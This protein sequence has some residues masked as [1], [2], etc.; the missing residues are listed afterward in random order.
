[1]I[2]TISWDGFVGMLLA[3]RILQKLPKKGRRE[4]LL[5]VF[6]ISGFT[7]LLLA[8][9]F[10]Y[11]LTTEQAQYSPL[12]GPLVNYH[13]EFMIAVATLGLAVGAGTFYLL[14]A[15]VEKKDA[16]VKWNANLLLKFLNEDERAVI[17]LILKRKGVA[18]QTEIASLEGMGRV[19]AHRTIAKLLKRGVI[20][21][22]KAG[23][24]NILQMPDE[25]LEGLAPEK[26]KP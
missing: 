26:G 3:E 4:L 8:L 22:R 16:E 1:V 24:I 11:H 12:L 7:F 17:E 23:K 19:R 9:V 6:I 20:T 15:I 10:T 5:L 14:T 25:L 13:V 2:E 21:V 18:Y